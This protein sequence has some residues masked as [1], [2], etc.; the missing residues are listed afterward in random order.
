MEEEDGRGG[1]PDAKRRR[2]FTRRETLK[3]LAELEG[4]VA[5]AV[6]EIVLSSLV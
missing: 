4:N 2:G 1:S 3:K 5:A 6:G